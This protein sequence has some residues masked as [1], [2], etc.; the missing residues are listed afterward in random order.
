M[1]FEFNLSTKI[2][3]I[4]NYSN[5]DLSELSLFKIGSTLTFDSIYLYFVSPIA[6]ISFCL[7]LFSIFIINK[8]KTNSNN[9]RNLYTY[10]K[11]YLINSSLLSF[12]VIFSFYSYSPRYFQFALN[13]LA[14]I[15]RCHIVNS[16]ATTLYFYSNIFDLI[17]TFERLSIFMH[18]LDFFKRKS[19]YT[20]SLIGLIA[21][22]II[23][24]PIFFF[25][26]I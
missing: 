26:T 8:I 1:E 25:G 15:Y 19:P 24:S 13:Y 10:F 4:Q 3:N 6:F 17:I 23:N 22:T 11:L 5:N 21:C 7:N 18:H 9:H 12:I 2:F 16:L 20:I 14:R